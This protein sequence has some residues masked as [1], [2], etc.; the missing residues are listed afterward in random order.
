MVERTDHLVINGT[1]LFEPKTL[2]SGVLRDAEV[3][4]LPTNFFVRVIRVEQRVHLALEEFIKH[5][6]SR[7]SVKAVDR[8]P[9]L[10]VSARCDERHTLQILDAATLVPLY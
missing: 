2:V 6:R 8:A 9:L 7:G 3:A 1:F 4:H 5:L 10:C